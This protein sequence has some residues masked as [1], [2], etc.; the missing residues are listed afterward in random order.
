MPNPPPSHASFVSRQ[1]AIGARYAGPAVRSAA[2]SGH[3]P[4]EPCDGVK[5]NPPPG[6]GFFHHVCNPYHNGESQA[7]AMRR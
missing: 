3:Q 1:S 6:G 2:E 7:R 4:I 5:E